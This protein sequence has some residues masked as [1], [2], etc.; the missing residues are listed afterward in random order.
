MISTSKQLLPKRRHKLKYT[1]LILNCFNNSVTDRPKE[2][3]KKNAE[4]HQTIANQNHSE[5]SP[6]YR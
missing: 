2:L 5:V 1:I 6:H 3:K 4:L